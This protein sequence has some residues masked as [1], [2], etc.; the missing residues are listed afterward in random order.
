MKKDTKSHNNVIKTKLLINGKCVDALSG[1]TFETTN[2]ATGEV[3]AE[4][5]SAKAADVDL[6]V[7]AAQK[8]MCGPW[9]KMTPGERGKLLQKTADLI[10]SNAE[11]LAEMDTVDMGRPISDSLFD[12][13]VQVPKVLNFFSGAS[14]T[15]RGETIPV[16]LDKF[17]CT[18]R[19]PYGVVGAIIPWNYPL[20][21]AVLKLAPILGAGN[22]LILK[23]SELSSR[24]ALEL[25]HLCLEAGIPDGAVNILT[26]L[27]PTAGAA[28]ARHNAIEKLSFTGSREVGRLIMEEAAKS[29]LK[30]ITLELGGKSPIIVFEDANMEN[31]IAAAMT[32][33]FFNQGQTCTATSR[34][35]VEEKIAD[36]FLER[37]VAKAK[38]I[39]VG[40][41]MKADTQL[42]AIASKEQYDTILG[43]IEKGKCE[44]ASLILGGEPPDDPELQS[45]LFLLPTVFTDI[46][47]EMTIAREEIFGPVLA[48]LT[49]QGE[50]EAVSI[51]NSVEYGLAASVWTKNIS[52]AHRLTQTLNSGIIWINTM[53]P[54]NPA[55]PAG[56][57]RQSGFGKEGGL[58]SLNEF[59]RRKTVWIDLSKEKLPWPE[60]STV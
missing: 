18:L 46:N 40:D 34:L 8:S 28:I 15:L 4:V 57:F 14:D 38:K 59:S 37:L 54:E 2:P 30:S 45:G 53:M 17:A 32:S 10:E 5:A 29:N 39:K 24:S 9:G 23:P 21:N 42:G 50:D 1:E 36:E 3:I 35:I 44:G 7:K 20:S 55:V 27:G 19:E 26:G 58:E 41:P 12:A 56:G 48:V 31:A 43:Y 49:F 47:M 6:A 11:E 51:A 52:R 22:A 60:G 25:G 33:I 16:G 13:E